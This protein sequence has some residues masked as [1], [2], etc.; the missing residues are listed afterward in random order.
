MRNDLDGAR[1]LLLDDL[2]EFAP[3]RFEVVCVF[4]A[5]GAGELKDKEDE[6]YGLRVV[7]ACT[8][9]DEYIEKETKRLQNE[10]K[11]WTATNDNAIQARAAVAALVG[12]A[13]R[14]AGQD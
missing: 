3:R 11:V 8:S 10:R 1:R 7:Y 9:A 4:D 2:L 12:V 14:G 13:M 6:H 5:A